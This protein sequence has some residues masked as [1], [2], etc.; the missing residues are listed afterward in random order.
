MI[1]QE[2]RKIKILVILL[3]FLI[4]FGGANIAWGIVNGMWFS[5]A[6]GLFCAVVSSW[7]VMLNMRTLE[8]MKAKEEQILHEMDKSNP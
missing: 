4:A 1:K 8:R 3:L 7:C 5:I 2:T 6:A